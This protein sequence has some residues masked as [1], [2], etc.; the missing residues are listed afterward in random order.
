MGGFKKLGLAFLFWSVS[1]LTWAR[2]FEVFA[3]KAEVSDL[4]GDLNRNLN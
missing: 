2:K 1:A 3:S 4:W